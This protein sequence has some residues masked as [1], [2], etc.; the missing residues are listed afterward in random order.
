MLEWA[1][2]APSVS[3]RY[4]RLQTIRRFACALKAED[5]RHQVPPD[6]AFGRAPRRHRKCHIFAQQ[7]IKQLLRAAAQLK[8]KGSLRPTMYIALFSL[9][10]AT[11]L[12]ISEA[13]K[14]QMSDITEDGLLI[15]E[16]K[17]QKSRLVPLHAS[18][19]HG[20]RQYLVARSRIRTITPHV[21]VSHRGYALPYDTVKSTF[22]Y[23]ARSA[24]MREGPGHGGCRIH[25]IRHTFAVRLLEQCSGDR[26]AI[27]QH[28]T[29]RATQAA[30]LRAF[31]HK[32][33]R[34]GSVPS[35]IVSSRAQGQL[36]ERMLDNP[37]ENNC[38][39]QMWVE[40]L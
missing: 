16:T 20:L 23:L 7:E 21:F 31:C 37:G 32:S 6:D 28:M 9:L 25:D 13:L 26:R 29:C 4:D 1:A 5:D 3:R 18:A 36:R 35:W 24:G 22:L 8:P 30:T 11:G 38:F 39:Q 27:A 15:R 40:D 12:R 10:A 19:H 33:R 17:F 14:L 34:E 2:R